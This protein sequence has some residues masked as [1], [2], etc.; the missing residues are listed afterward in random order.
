MLPFTSQRILLDRELRAEWA[1]N[2]PTGVLVS[3]ENLQN[4]GP[5]PVDAERLYRNQDYAMHAW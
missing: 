1:S 5:T 4:S 3:L 2:I